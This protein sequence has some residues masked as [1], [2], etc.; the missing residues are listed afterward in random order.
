MCT[1]ATKAAR[2]EE[3]DEIDVYKAF[4]PAQIEKK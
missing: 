2:H 4:S 1:T 3:K